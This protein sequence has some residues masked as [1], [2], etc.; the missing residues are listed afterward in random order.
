[1]RTERT[2]KMLAEKDGALGWLIFNNPARHNAVSMAMWQAMPRILDEFEADPDI[3]VVV[4]RGAGARAFISGADISEFETVRAS[5]F[6][7]YEEAYERAI[8]RL[9]R[10]HKPKIAMIDGYCMGGGVAVALGCDLRLASAKSRFAIPAAKLGVSYRVHAIK[11]LMDVVGPAMT[12]EIFFTARP[13]TAAEALGSGWVNRVVPEEDLE[14]LVHEYVT[15]IAA[16]AP[17]TIQGVKAT[18][19]AL[20]QDPPER[21]RAEAERLVAPCFDGEDHNEGRRTFMEE[22]KPSIRGR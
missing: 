10:T 16:N 4:L 9:Y 11:R 1:M 3:R 19:E 22:R 6:E 21:T 8:E 5:N 13:F 7:A 15:A 14:P 20:A 17:L 18:V 2:D 12:K